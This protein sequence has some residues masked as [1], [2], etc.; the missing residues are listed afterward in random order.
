MESE[1]RAVNYPC[2]HIMTIEQSKNKEN[3]RGEHTDL[4][5]PRAVPSACG[6]KIQARL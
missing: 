4:L 6:T 1:Q 2:L 5:D 3:R